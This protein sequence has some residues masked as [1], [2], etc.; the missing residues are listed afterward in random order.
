LD[1]A[2]RPSRPRAPRRCLAF[3]FLA[4]APAGAAADADDDVLLLL[5]FNR[6]EDLAR[7]TLPAHAW[8][9]PAGGFGGRDAVCGGS[10]LLASTRGRCAFVTNVRSRLEKSRSSGAARAAPSR[11]RLP[12][13]FV[14][15]PLP[16]AEFVQVLDAGGDLAG[17]CFVAVDAAAVAAGAPAAWFATNRGGAASAGA[18]PIS[19]GVWH[20]VSNAPELDPPWP[21][22][23]AGRRR[24]EAL[25]ARGAVAGSSA[26]SVGGVPWEGIFEIMSDETL[27]ETDP[28]KLPATGF[29]PDLEAKLSGIAVAPFSLDGWGGE[30][31]TRSTSVLALR[32]G[33]AAE[34]RERSRGAGGAWREARVAFRMDLSGG[35]GAPG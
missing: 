10:W 18:A 30:F 19:T 32:R 3:L 22:V 24:L 17:F 9:A 28:A 34:L 23:E 16:P 35:G 12:V 4:S 31:G 14:A 2:L 6:D 15:S 5:A 21:K 25:C 13:D 11:G 1:L 26:G 7:A 20:G 29:G 27:L 8:A 33:G